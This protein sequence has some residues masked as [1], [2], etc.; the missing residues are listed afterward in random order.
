[1]L[2]IGFL[3]TAGGQALV[4]RAEGR[5]VESRVSQRRLF[6]KASRCVAG[7]SD[8]D[9]CMLGGHALAGAASFGVVVEKFPRPKGGAALVHQT[10]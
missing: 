1:V 9:A 6:T 2:T 7:R 3:F 4:S 8:N 10:T 5:T